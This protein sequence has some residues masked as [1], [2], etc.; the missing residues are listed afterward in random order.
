M[1]LISCLVFYL[2][3]VNNLGFSAASQEQ[4]LSSSVSSAASTRANVCQETL[5]PRSPEPRQI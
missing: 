1:N 4:Y 3:N 5:P 2:S